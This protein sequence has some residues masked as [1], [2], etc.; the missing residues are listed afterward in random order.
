MHTKKRQNK[1]MS[2]VCCLLSVA[3]REETWRACLLLPVLKTISIRGIGKI[4]PLWK[5]CLVSRDSRKM[6]NP[7]K[8]FFVV[9]LGVQEGEEE[10]MAAS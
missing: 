1:H 7:D 8:L 3:A 4:V 2:A 10:S 9:L 6:Q 5:Q